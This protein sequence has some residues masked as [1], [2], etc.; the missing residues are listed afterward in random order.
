MTLKCLKSDRIV[1]LYLKFPGFELFIDRE[2]DP[3]GNDTSG[4]KQTNKKA[5]SFPTVV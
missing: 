2:N 3:F 5:G 4:K 1:D